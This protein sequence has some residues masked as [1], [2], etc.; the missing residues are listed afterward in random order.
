LDCNLTFC[1]GC[2]LLYQRVIDVRSPVQV[3]AHLTTMASDC[4]EVISGRWVHCGKTACHGG[5]PL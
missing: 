2:G 3:N 5:L 4:D 1:D